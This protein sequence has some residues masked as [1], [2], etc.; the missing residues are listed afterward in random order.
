[1]LARQSIMDVIY[2]DNT[3]REC[4]VSKPASLHNKQGSSQ[5]GKKPSGTVNSDAPHARAFAKSLLN[6]LYDHCDF[7]LNIRVQ[8]ALGCLVGHL[9][10]LRCNTEAAARAVL[11]GTTTSAIVIYITLSFYLTYLLVLRR[12]TRLRFSSETKRGRSRRN[13]QKGFKRSSRL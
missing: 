6:T 7:L 2:L 5:H 1:M 8:S 13:F 9:P 11:V 12:Q 3:E 4:Y 10:A